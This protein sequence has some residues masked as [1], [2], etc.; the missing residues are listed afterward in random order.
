[1]TWIEAKTEQSV[2]VRAKRDDAL[3]IIKDICRIGV[4]F[5]GVDRVEDRG[6][7]KFRF[8]IAERST[9]GVRFVG[10]YVN[11]YEEKGPDTYA[12]HSLEGNMKVRGFWQVRGVD[13]SVTITEQIATELEVP[14]PRMLKA[15]V[16]LFAD[17]ELSTGV[18]AQLEG[19]RRALEGR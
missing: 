18:K 11:L 17:R 9:L 15:P 1:M 14:V 8:L 7:G 6:G 4:M 3:R 5:P 13:G 10:D 16:Q 12:F 2:A 19:I